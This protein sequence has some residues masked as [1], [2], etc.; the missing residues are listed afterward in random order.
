MASISG[1]TR[2]S[3]RGQIVIPKALRE[4][5]GLAEGDDVLVLFDGQRLELAPLP[6]AAEAGAEAVGD[7]VRECG[8]SYDASPRHG[9]PS[10]RASKVWADRIRAAARIKRLR[11]ESQPDNLEELLSEARRGLWEEGDHRG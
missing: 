6:Q 8:A 3:S 10:K 9:E 2:M 7:R 4:A 1:R 11:Q 5:A